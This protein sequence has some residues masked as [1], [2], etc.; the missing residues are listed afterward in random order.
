MKTVLIHTMY[1]VLLASLL[2]MNIVQA[3]TI[4]NQQHTIREMITNPYC[5]MPEVK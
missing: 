3:R 2:Y 4:T 5:L 1:T